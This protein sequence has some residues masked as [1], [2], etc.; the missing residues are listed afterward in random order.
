M[1]VASFS[2]VGTNSIPQS[3]D[4]LWR[5]VLKEPTTVSVDLWHRNK[6]EDGANVV[7]KRNVVRN[8][9]KSLLVR[10]GGLFGCDTANAP[11]DPVAQ[12]SNY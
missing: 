11:N 9:I 6:K 10:T 12:L 1:F 3:H 2:M 7:R 4:S 8:K 5:Y